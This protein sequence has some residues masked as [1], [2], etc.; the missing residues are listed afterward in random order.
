[1]VFFG[2][3]SEP[4]AEAVCSL[5]QCNAQ[6]CLEG[7]NSGSKVGSTQSVCVFVCARVCDEGS[8]FSLFV[9]QV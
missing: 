7:N 9:Y 4:S 8:E 2:G 1:M 5:W 3:F 6:S